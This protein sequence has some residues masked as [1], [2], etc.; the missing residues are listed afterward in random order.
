MWK[1]NESKLFRLLSDASQ[2]ANEEMQKVFVQFVKQIF[3]ICYFFLSTKPLRV[4]GYLFIP[5]F[6]LH[7]KKY[8][9]CTIFAA[10]KFKPSKKP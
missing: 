9:F 10:Y 2:V 5:N 6:H 3:E 1:I 4:G 8:Y 7:A